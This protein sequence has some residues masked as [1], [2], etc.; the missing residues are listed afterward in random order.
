MSDDAVNHP[1]HY[2]SSPAKCS[3]CGTPIECIDVIE[4]MT[5]NRGNAVKYLWRADLKGATLQD[6]HK[7]RWYVDREIQRITQ[8]QKMAPGI[9]EERAA[10]LPE[11][12]PTADTF[13][14]NEYAKLADRTAKNFG[15]DQQDMIHATLGIMSEGG[16]LTT[17][18][19]A[20]AIYGKPFDRENA[21]EEL[22]D[23]LW[24]IALAARVVGV[25]LGE[26]A[27]QNIEKLRKRYPDKYSDQAALA[28]ADK[29]PGQ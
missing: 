16:E 5:L 21:A 24:Y 9:L 20:Y 17:M 8:E 28:R 25:S 13:T 27:Q 19:K 12:T 7:A 2:T 14:L 4:Y 26:I 23:L 1:K 18:V 11:G 3:H 10:D 15:S 29:A 22:G 6:L